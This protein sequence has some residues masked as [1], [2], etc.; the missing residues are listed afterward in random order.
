MISSEVSVSTCEH[1]MV[2]SNTFKR[3]WNSILV[4]IPWWSTEGFIDLDGS[5]FD[6][7][8]THLTSPFFFYQVLKIFTSFFFFEPNGAAMIRFSEYFLEDL[9]QNTLDMDWFYVH[10][11]DYS[12]LN[13]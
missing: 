9:G 2:Y 4:Y 5:F 12:I 13:F 7:L 8:V 6:F 3:N 1:E 11:V 10:I